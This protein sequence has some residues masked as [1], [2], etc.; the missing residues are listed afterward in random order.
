[1]TWSI[2]KGSPQKNLTQKLLGKIK[3]MS[4]VAGY[5]IM[6]IWGISVDQQWTDW[7]R[8]QENNLIHNTHKNNKVP[9]NKFNKRNQ[10]A[11]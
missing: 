3:S 2:P 7:E 10:R 8:N 6:E 4:K 5:T 1:M 11:F 9:W